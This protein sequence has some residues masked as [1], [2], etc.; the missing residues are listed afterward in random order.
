MT[1]EELTQEVY[2]KLLRTVQEEGKMNKSYVRQA[3]VFVC[4]DEYRKISDLDNP[5]P[6]S[7]DTPIDH[8]EVFQD[9]ERL[10]SLDIFEPKELTV[11]LKL[12]EG[13]RNP[14]VREDL[15]I[16]KMTYY[17]LLKKLKLKYI[18][19]SGTVEI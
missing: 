14:E 15:G 10:M 17:T 18:E 4:I 5:E 12:M 7:P 19:N 6:L 11:M 3:V 2:L 13:L 8:E 16:P 9:V 1:I